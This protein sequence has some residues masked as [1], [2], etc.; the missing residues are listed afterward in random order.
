MKD[1]LPTT[2]ET[3]APVPSKHRESIIQGAH[4]KRVRR[5]GS[6]RQ[7]EIIVFVLAII[8][9][10]IVAAYFLLRPQDESYTLRD[11]STALVEVRTIRDDLQLGGTVRARTEATIRAPVPGILE[12][13]AVDVGDW[14]I[15]GE[16]VAVLDAEALR[17]TYEA[18][19]QSEVPFP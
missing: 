1:D 7:L 16:V 11:Y 19:Q 15:A 8:A 4:A 13:L 3:P 6:R 14:I 12:S 18:L 17:D 2:S 9:V 5:P 10:A